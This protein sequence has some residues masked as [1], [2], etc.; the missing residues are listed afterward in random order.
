M[1]VFLSYNSRGFSSIKKSFM[2]YLI[3]QEVV[4]SKLPIL[5]SQETFIL[6][7][8]SYKISSAFPGFQVQ[9]N[10]AVKTSHEKGQPKNGMF[11]AYPESLK[12]CVTDVSPGY[13]RLQAI[14]IKFGSSS[15]L[16]INSYFPTDARRPD[17]DQSYLRHSVTVEI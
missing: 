15:T 6:R 4:C 14:I 3:S 10:P 8:N 11:I 16:L 1:F 17:A 9:V 2:N 13:W 7:E 5:C 12:N